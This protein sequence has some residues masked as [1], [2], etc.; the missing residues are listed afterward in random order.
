MLEILRHFNLQ[1]ETSHWTARTGFNR[2]SERCLCCSMLCFF[3]LAN[4]PSCAS[5]VRYMSVVCAMC[6]CVITTQSYFLLLNAS[7][8]F[9][10]DVLSCVL[11][12]VS[13]EILMLCNK[14]FQI[15]FH[16]SLA[17]EFLENPEEV[18]DSMHSSFVRAGS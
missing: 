14:I 15:S 12:F 3:S 16:L 4:I 9:R 6:M 7:K 5:V 1:K 17:C 11:G 10:I 2:L 8:F 18:L 13:R